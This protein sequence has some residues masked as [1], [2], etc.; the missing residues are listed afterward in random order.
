MRNHTTMLKKNSKQLFLKKEIIVP[1]LLIW[2][3]NQKNIV[4]VAKIHADWYIVRLVL[5]FRRNPVC[6]TLHSCCDQGLDR[7]H[8]YTQQTFT[9][10][11]II[12][13]C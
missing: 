7:R 1:S 2:Q 9:V 8:T 6:N 4:F 10:S 11:G 12:V 13:L 3:R 5:H